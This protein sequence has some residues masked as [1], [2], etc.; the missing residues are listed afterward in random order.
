MEQLFPDM[1][2][3]DSNHGSL[4]YRRQKAS[5]LP[6]AAIKSYNELFRSRRWLEMA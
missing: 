1:D 6:K 2:L 3:M 4:V 5:G